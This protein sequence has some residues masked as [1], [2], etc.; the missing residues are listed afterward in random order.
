MLLSIDEQ[1]AGCVV[2]GGDVVGI[3]GMPHPEGVRRHAETEAE[4][5]GAAELEVLGC[6]QD[7][8]TPADDVEEHDEPDHAGHRHKLG[9]HELARPGVLR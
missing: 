4:H 7:H 2:D 8:Q 1:F 6:R 9:A 3:E 5:P